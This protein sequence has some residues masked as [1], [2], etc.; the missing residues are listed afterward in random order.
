MPMSGG[1]AMRDGVADG[2]ESLESAP[3]PRH[4]VYPG[5]RLRAT[6]ARRELAALRGAGAGHCGGRTAERL[7]E[8]N[9]SDHV[10]KSIEITGS[11]P[12]GITEAIDRGIE[13]AAGT[14]RH[15]DWFEV[16]DLRGHV[17][18]GKV[19]HYQVTMKVGFRL[20]D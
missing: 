14:V 20:E 11:S 3:A 9:V 13:K 5:P 16:T 1:A 7:Q 10:Y 18:D 17:A 4:R 8:G 19:A 6:A 12:S 2:P 15:I